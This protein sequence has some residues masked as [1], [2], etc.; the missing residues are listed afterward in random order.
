MAALIS[1]LCFLA[2]SIKVSR[3]GSLNSDHQ[4]WTVATLVKTLELSTL[5]KSFGTFTLG[6]TSKSR[7]VI[8]QETNRNVNMPIIN[9]FFIFKN[10]KLIRYFQCLLEPVQWY[11][12]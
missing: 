3:M 10:F 11:W 8:P 12:T 1:K 6:T 9:K 2:F 4:F 7:L 5:K